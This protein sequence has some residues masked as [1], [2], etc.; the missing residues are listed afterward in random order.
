MTASWSR[1]AALSQ[2]PFSAVL[3]INSSFVL[4]SRIWS[5]REEVIDTRPVGE[6]ES[7]AGWE[8]RFDIRRQQMVEGGEHDSLSGEAGLGPVMEEGRAEFLPSERRIRS[9][10][11]RRPARAW[12]ELTI[13]EDR[14]GSLPG[15]FG[16]ITSRVASACAD[17]PAPP[18]QTPAHYDQVG[19]HLASTQVGR[20]RVG[21]GGCGPRLGCPVGIHQSGGCRW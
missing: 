10:V 14:V 13:P 3:A 17:E 9:A 21:R 18:P 6:R 15:G 11:P 5:W 2:V 1:T 7:D 4:R 12:T 19:E 16:S 20:D 8:L